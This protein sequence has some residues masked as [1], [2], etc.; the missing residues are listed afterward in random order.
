LFI[1]ETGL[2]ISSVDFQ[3]SSS[4]SSPTCGVIRSGSQAVAGAVS[5]VSEAAATLRAV[6]SWLIEKM[7]VALPFSSRM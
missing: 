1:R 6:M 2:P 3:S 7:A 5:S 4:S